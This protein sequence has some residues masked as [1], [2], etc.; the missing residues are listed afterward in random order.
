MGCTP[1]AVKDAASASRNL[2]V[3]V[4]HAGLYVPVHSLDGCRPTY[5]VSAEFTPQPTAAV[6]LFRIQGSATKTI[7]IARIAVEGVST[8]NA[9]VPIALQRES[10]AGAGGTPVTPT[11]AK[12]D[13]AFAAASAVV[14]HFTTTLVAAGTAVGGPL[15]SGYLTTNVVTTPTLAAPRMPIFP[16]VGSQAQ[17]IVLRGTGDYL[18]LSNTNAGNLSAGTKV[19]YS[20]EWIEDD[21]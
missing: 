17:S 12:L 9:N 19:A 10:T 7:R 2:A 18:V 15:W 20:V 13:P 6:V 5:R 11:V 21:T 3:N 4:D 1:F 14:K 8:A 16:E